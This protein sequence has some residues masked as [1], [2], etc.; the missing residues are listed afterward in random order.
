MKPEVD[1][2]RSDILG[3]L[4][5]WS[6]G[7][8][9]MHLRLAASIRDA[10][11]SGALL[12]GRRLPS[13]RQLADLIAVSR[14]TVV[15]AYDHLRE[16]GLLTSRRGSGTS[17]SPIVRPRR[18]R[19][20]AVPEGR[21]TA[22]VRR[23]ITGE[24]DVISLAIPDWDDG[25]AIG[26]AARETI[27]FDLGNLLADTGYQPRGL[28]ALREAI[29][30][31]YSAVGLPTTAGQILITNGAHPAVLL[32]TQLYVR[33]DACVVVENPSWPAYLDI[34]TSAGAHLVDVPLDDDGIDTERL[35]RAISATS[36]AFVYVMPTY[37]DPTGILMSAARRQAVARI[38]ERHQAPIV[39]DHSYI[40]LV[41]AGTPPPIAAFADP[42]AEILNVGSLDNA[43]WRGLRVGWLRAPSDIIDALTYR[44]SVIDLGGPLIEHA[45]AAR[46]LRQHNSSIVER[47]RELPR[48]L[49]V[50]EKLLRDRLPSWRWQRPQGGIALWVTLPRA[51][52]T[53]YA[54]LALRHGVEVLPGPVLDPVGLD[55]T[56]IRVPFTPPPHVAA[57]FV[58]RLA[59]AWENL[60]CL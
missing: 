32:A 4:G 41:S 9:P 27:D 57:E 51:A 23:L 53:A 1:F 43:V 13:E 38:A 36:P 39:E 26:C 34:F 33:P 19:T 37:H 5:S 54:Q 14:T 42:Q 46:L 10:I 15:T 60:R 12:P 50:L 21:T 59:L 35:D 47:S 2:V 7:S 20:A 3:V 44:K 45:I 16:E 28:L 11:V 25:A 6:T 31:R 22:I 52:A 58:N 18:E 24:R 48:R 56:H 49:D 55:D 40:G 8:G 29:A 30:E 17:V